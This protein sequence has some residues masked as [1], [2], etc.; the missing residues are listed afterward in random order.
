MDAGQVLARQEI[1]DTLV[2]YNLAGD[3]G[4]IDEL[5]DCFCEDGVLQIRD[6]WEA[7]GRRAIG[8]RLAA[9]RDETQDRGAGALLR[10]HLTTHRSDFESETEARAWTYFLV[11]THEGPDH[12]GRYVDRLRRVGDRWLLAHRTVIVEWRAAGGRSPVP[13]SG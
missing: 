7:R 12:A 6:D 1:F 9:V 13:G 5:C 4:R 8:E 10:H 11:V 2:R 3:R